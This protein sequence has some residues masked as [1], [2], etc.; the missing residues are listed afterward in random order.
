MQHRIRLAGSLMRAANE[1]I[2][3][4]IHS[5]ISGVG[6]TWLADG[7]PATLSPFP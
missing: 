3:T 2:P 4:F 1:S 5:G 7:E 6:R